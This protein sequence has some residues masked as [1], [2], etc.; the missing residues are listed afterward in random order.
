M[1]KVIEGTGISSKL[2]MAIK[3][4]YKDQQSAVFGD[5]NYFTIN[6]GVYTPR[7]CALATALHHLP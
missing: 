4:M 5:T 7:Q 1:W 2:L 3:S 6:T